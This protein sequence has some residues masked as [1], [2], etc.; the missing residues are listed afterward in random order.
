MPDSSAD[1]PADPPAYDRAA[2]FH[3]DGPL[4]PAFMEEAIRALLR[5]CPLDPAEPAHW[6][7]RRMDSALNSLAALHPR[8][9]IEV[10]LSVQAISAY[11]AANVCWR[12]GMN[13]HVPNGDSTRHVAAATT[14]AR[15]FEA[16]PRALERRQAKPLAIP[17][18]RPA[19][20]VWPESDAART[21]L[22]WEARCRRGEDS[23]A[24][25][26]VRKQKKVVAWTPRALAVARQMRQRDELAAENDG[27]DIAGTE[28]ILPGGGMI[29]PRDPTPQQLA[30]MARRS[31]LMCRREWQ[32]NLRRGIREYPKI[33]PIR[34]GDLIP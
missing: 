9:E 4:H 21:V 14:A 10:M 34:V 18:G 15:T 2:I 22:H 5:A 17:V 32:D 20:R 30:Y 25:G 27:L 29:V 23:P 26:P 16:M 11:H 3:P 13:H 8:D 28:G 1:P 24:A 31:E 19:P 6:A 12:I 7:Y 33:R